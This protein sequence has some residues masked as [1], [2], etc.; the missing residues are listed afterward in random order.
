MVGTKR[1]VT[2]S[3]MKHFNKI[4]SVAHPVAATR[5]RKHEVERAKSVA[6]ATT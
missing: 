4:E 3:K 1:T 2:I 6:T 5:S